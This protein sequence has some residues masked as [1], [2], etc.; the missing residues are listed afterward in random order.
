MATIRRKATAGSE[1]LAPTDDKELIAWLSKK[2]TQGKVRI[3]EL[4]MRL[5]MAMV[6]GHQWAV[7]DKDR[8]RFRTPSTRPNDPNPPVRIT[9]NKIG[10]IVER[11]ISK[12]TKDAPLPLARPVSEIDGD[13]DAARVAS[14]IIEHEMDRLKWN[15]LLPEFYQWPVTLGFSFLHLYWD[16][17][18]GEEVGQVEEETLYQGNI[19]IDQVPAFEMSVDPNANT[20]EDALWCVRTTA[21]TREAIWNKWGVIPEAPEGGRTLS[22]DVYA[23]ANGG[24]GYSGT[25]E[26]KAT[27]D[28]YYV[29]Q[30]W[31]KPNRAAPKGLCVTW[32]GN[33]ILEKYEEF[34]YEHGQ[35]PFIQF[36]MLP[37]MGTREGRTWLNDLIPLQIDYN[38]AR[39]REAT[40]RRQLAPKVLAPIGSI[41]PNRVTARVEIITYAPTG[42]KPTMMIPD[43]G[44]MAQF[45]EGMNR[46]DQEMGDRAGQSDATVGKAPASQPAA[47][48]LALQDADDTKLA[49]SVK[50]MNAGI[51]K[52]GKMILSLVHQFWSEDR[53]VRTWSDQDGQLEIYHYSR[54]DVANGLDVHIASEAGVPRSPAARAQ[55][56]LDLHKMGVPPFDDPMVLMK[57]LDMSGSDLVMDALNVDTRQAHRENGWLASGQAIEIHE[58]DKHFVHI[59]EHN[60]FRK[61]IDYEQLTPQGKAVVDAHVAAHQELVSAMFQQGNLM[62]LMLAGFPIGGG[63]GGAGGKT[64]T[65]RI[66]FRDVPPQVQ[67]Q[68]EM[69][70]GLVAPTSQS[71]QTGIGG[72]GQPGHVPGQTTDSQAAHGATAR[73]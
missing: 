32:C 5:S 26:S 3:P 33:T 4:Q 27:I 60:N 21:W 65:E 61:S 50:Q 16:P 7:W 70:A 72:P 59:M 45:E 44:W 31:M 53:T 38:D 6:L 49:L 69:Q 35:L 30:F 19:K 39:S 11:A 25:Y 12:M 9:A 48:I 64:P 8:G 51:E 17:E 43:S 56:A 40:I 71:Q 2:N 29:H 13:M 23:L 52:V 46:A 28:F 37:G 24:V 15:A 66:D 47:S 42:E 41:D 67:Q 20:F 10:A 57:F 63:M 68:M 58:F 1:F 54:S 18:D 34:P 73:K 36:N 62:G 14:R 22:D 55:L